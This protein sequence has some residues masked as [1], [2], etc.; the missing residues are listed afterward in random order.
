MQNSKQIINNGI[1]WYIKRIIYHNQ[2]GLIP[3]KQSLLTIW[4]VVNAT[5]YNS[6]VNRIKE[7]KNYMISSINVVKSFNKIQHS[8]IFKMRKRKLNKLA[9]EKNFLNFIKDN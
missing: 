9:T 5:D 7:K 2:L 6:P 1:Q 4:K 8:F 3:G